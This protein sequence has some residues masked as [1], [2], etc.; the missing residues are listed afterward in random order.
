[1]GKKKRLSHELSKVDY[2]QKYLE[3][4]SG[5]LQEIL[6]LD[7]SEKKRMEEHL[8][9]LLEKS[10]SVSK[11]ELDELKKDYGPKI[12]RDGSDID[13]LEEE[14]SKVEDYEEPAD[15]KEEKEEEL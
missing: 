10:R 7:D 14:Q 3:H 11:E 6:K 12:K 15:D 1:L 5:A 2:I 4:V 8:R 13:D 9:I